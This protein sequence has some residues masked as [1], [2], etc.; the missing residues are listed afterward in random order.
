MPEIVKRVPPWMCPDFGEN[1]TKIRTKI[2]SRKSQLMLSDLNYVYVIA[3]ARFV[4]GI[5]HKRSVLFLEHQ[6]IIIMWC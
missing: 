2:F 3:K 1:W 5:A 4:K 6:S